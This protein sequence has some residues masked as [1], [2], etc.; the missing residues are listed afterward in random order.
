MAVNL[1][2]SGIGQLALRLG[3]VA[4]DQVRECL[5]ELD[6]KKAPAP[7][8]LRMMERKKYLTPW[9]ANKLLKGDLDGYFLGGYRILYKIASGSFGR[10]YR[11]DD[12]RVGQVVAV[13]VLRNKWTMDKQK[14]DLFLREGKLGLTIRH[15]NIVSVLAVN[16]DSKT[17]QYFIV[18]E[19]VEG[20][21][22]R[23]LL[24]A[25]KKI[26]ADESLRIIDECA[27]GLAY[28]HARGLTHRD[29]KPTNILIAVPTG[30]AKL[31]DFGLAEISQGSSVH[32]QRQDERDEDVAVDRTVDY[33]GLEKATGQKP[34][35]VRSDIYFLGSVLY[36]CLT[37]APLMP[38]TRD[39]QVRMQ[40]RRYIDVEET[41]RTNGPALGLTPPLMRL[42]AKMVA[43]E[44][45]RRFQTPAQLVEAIQACRADLTAGIAEVSVRGPTGPRTLFVVEE[46]E[47]L[48][49]AFREKFKEQG[50]RVLISSD[51]GQAAKR[52]QQQSYHAAIIDARTVGRDGVTA[53]NDLLRAADN[54]G[55]QVAVILLLSE[56]Q[57]SWQRDA[58]NHEQ[59]A[60]LRDPGIS[61]RL[62]LKTL[63]Q[64][65]P[66]EKR[67]EG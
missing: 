65:I 6:D 58:R 19:F 18:M 49:D 56:E 59:G 15:P 1:D 25:R 31:V 23:D 55:Q 17:G 4:D 60:V 5:T 3:L 12:P 48:Q 66:K 2:A 62:L 28:S 8:M 40:A 50:Y 33:A 34:G 61:V 41:L 37:G 63:D 45:T 39:R 54:F 53:Y 14:V 47:K 10:V 22:L 42:I 11:G 13:K 36:E 43:F 52:Y 29:I 26:E 46:N 9:Q 32:L 57:A 20:G 38:V 35:D 24:Q 44:P 64:L 16:Q 67:R 30:Q 27:Q 7:D 51:P 21:N